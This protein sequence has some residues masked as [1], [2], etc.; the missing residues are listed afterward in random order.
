MTSRLHACIEFAYAVKNGRSARLGPNGMTLHELFESI[1]GDVAECHAFEGSPLLVPVPRSGNSQPSREAGSDEYSCRSLA[2]FLAE[3][4]MGTFAELLTRPTA[5]YKPES[6]AMHVDTIS[7][8]P[9]N[10]DEVHQTI[11]LIDDVVTRGT[12]SAGCGRVLRQAGYAGELRLFAPAQTAAPQPNAL[13]ISNHV[14]SIVRHDEGQTFAK[15]T[16]LRVWKQD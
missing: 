5:A 15:R 9:P 7:A 3:R 14:E 12:T 11:V 4:G 2:I 10:A 1:A 13:Q 6:V 16:D 8:R